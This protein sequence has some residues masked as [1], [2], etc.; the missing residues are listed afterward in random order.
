MPDILY[1]SYRKYIGINHL[2]WLNNFSLPH[3]P[4]QGICGRIKWFKTLKCFGMHILCLKNTNDDRVLRQRIKLNKQECHIFYHIFFLAFISFALALWV[5]MVKVMHEVSR[6]SI[7]GYIVSESTIGCVNYI[8]FVT[9]N[10][11][12]MHKSYLMLTGLCDF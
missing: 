2:L 3:L 12:E 1:V 5:R 9:N 4:C 6:E 10:L 8:S 11:C 7:S